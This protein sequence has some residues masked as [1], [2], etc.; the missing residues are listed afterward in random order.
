MYAPSAAA[1]APEAPTSGTVELRVD[2]D[3]GE[4][5][6]DTA[7]EVEQQER[8]RAEPILDVVPED[9][10]EEHVA[11]QVQPAAVQEHA[12]EHPDRR[13]AEVVRRPRARP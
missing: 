5:R 8:D 2:D 10:Q 7:D 11:E 12:R 13:L 6:R 9:P 3:L 4:R 1:I